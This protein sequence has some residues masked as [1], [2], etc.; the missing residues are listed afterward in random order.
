MIVFKAGTAVEAKH[1]TGTWNPQCHWIVTPD[2][3]IEAAFIQALLD[4][5]VPHIVAY[6][7]RPWGNMQIVELQFDDDETGKTCNQ[8]YMKGWRKGGQ[9]VVQKQA[10]GKKATKRLYTDRTFI[11]PDGTEFLYYAPYDNHGYVIGKVV[12]ELEQR[13]ENRIEHRSVLEQSTV[14]PRGQERFWIA[15][16]TTEEERR[17]VLEAVCRLRAKN[18]HYGPGD[19]HYGESLKNICK[20]LKS[21]S[22][23]KVCSAIQ[24][25]EEVD[26]YLWREGELVGLENEGWR[27]WSG[28]KDEFFVN[29]VFCESGQDWPEWEEREFWKNIAPEVWERLEA[30]YTN[31]LQV[32]SEADR[33]EKEKSEQEEM[34]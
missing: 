4:K 33:K 18:S 23:G 2:E 34:P 16:E 24:Q 11:L 31:I 29:I 6:C 3:P 12:N 10:L 19:C 20:A 28:W 22:F 1:F 27:V 21:M 7:I 15:T 32:E 14:V 8:E 17:E 26:G 9:V 25:L 13:L 5:Y 30:E